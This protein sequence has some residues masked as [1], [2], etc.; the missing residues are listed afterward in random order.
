MSKVYKISIPPLG[1]GQQFY[2]KITLQLLDDKGQKKTP[3]AHKGLGAAHEKRRES[4]SE[5]V[6]CSMNSMPS[7]P[8]LWCEQGCLTSHDKL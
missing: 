7:R 3:T 8:F 6:W 5:V 2:K 1:L 4:L